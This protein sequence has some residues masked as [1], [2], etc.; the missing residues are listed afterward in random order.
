MC[1][2]EIMSVVCYRLKTVCVDFTWWQALHRSQTDN[3][4]HN[5]R[6][7]LDQPSAV[8]FAS[9]E[10]TSPAIMQLFNTVHLNII[11]IATASFQG[12]KSCPIAQPNESLLSFDL[13]HSINGIKPI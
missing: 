7:L 4:N 3:N 1:R 12:P 9:M 11:L 2:N 10:G 13:T 5:T 6:T 8:L